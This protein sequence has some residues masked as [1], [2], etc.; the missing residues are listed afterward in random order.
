MGYDDNLQLVCSTF[1]S[2][3]ALTIRTCDESFSIYGGLPAQK[4]TFF[5]HCFAQCKML[6]SLDLQQCHEVI[7]PRNVE[8]ILRTC[9]NLERLLLPKDLERDDWLNISCLDA[10]VLAYISE[11]RCEHLVELQMHPVHNIN[12]H[13]H[14]VD[15]KQWFE[16]MGSNFPNLTALKLPESF[17]C[18][19]LEAI[20]TSFQ[21]L[22][23]L[24]IDCC[25][26]GL[27]E[28]S[29]GDE[30]FLLAMSCQGFAALEELTLRIATNALTNR[31]ITAIARG[32]PGLRRLSLF[33]TCGIN[34]LAMEQVCSAFEHA[35]CKCD[36]LLHLVDNAASTSLQV[37]D[38]CRQFRLGSLDTCCS[39]PRHV[40][41]SV[42]LTRCI[43]FRD[44]HLR[45]QIQ[46]ATQ[47]TCISAL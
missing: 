35:F 21:K 39:I 19:A 44:F 32:C 25:E 36:Q 43:Y 26:G 47:S 6:R 4:Y 29:L 45:F 9:T 31:A 27:E 46:H 42:C 8:H 22:R 28:W 41:D 10:D 20:G 33:R 5:E 18:G 38:V 24:Q 12:E 34:G 7:S 11:V 16:R 2:M 40:L 15:L 30:P 23:V 3:R 14:P 37:F 13:C 1:P 17:G